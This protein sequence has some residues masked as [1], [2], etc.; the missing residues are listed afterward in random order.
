MVSIHYY[1][2]CQDITDNWSD[3]KI[4]LI[5]SIQTVASATELGL[6]GDKGWAF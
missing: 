3:N 6:I 2:K 4:E 5:Q 1:L